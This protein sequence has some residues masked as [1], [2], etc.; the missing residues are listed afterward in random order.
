MQSGIIHYMN[1]LLGTNWNEEI[2]DY[3][4]GGPFSVEPTT[5]SVHTGE[6]LHLMDEVYRNELRHAK[7]PVQQTI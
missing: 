3:S 2:F 6:V 5:D 7:G 1:K 4:F